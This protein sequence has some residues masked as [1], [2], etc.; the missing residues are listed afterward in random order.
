MKHAS[1]DLLRWVGW[2]LTSL[3]IVADGRLAAGKDEIWRLS[4]SAVLG[5]GEKDGVVI[6]D[7]G[8]VRLARGMSKTSE[9]EAARV[10]DLARLPEGTVVAATGD[11]GRV[12]SRRGDEAWK[13]LAEAG[14]SQALALAAGGDGSLVVGTGPGGWVV[15]VRFEGGEGAEKRER[16]G[17]EVK[18]VWDL[19]YGR[20]GTLYAA[21]GPAGQLW[22]KETGT[23]GKWT[24]VLDS[25]QAHLLSVAVAEDGVVSAGSDGG[26]LIYQVGRGG[27]VE[28][29]LDAPQE[30]IRCLATGPDGALYAGTASGSGASGGRR[31]TARLD[32]GGRIVRRASLRSAQERER[33]DD[34]AG[35]TARLQAGAAGENVVYRIERGGPAR[36]IFRAK[37]LVH[38]LAW[39]G[40]R[41]LVGTG[42]EGTIYEVRG[43]GRETTP[44]AKLDHGQILSLLAEPGGVVW[45]GCGSPGAVVRLEAA[46]RERGSLTSEVFDTKLASRFGS[47]EWRGRERAGTGVA[48]EVRTGGVAEP[49]ATWSAWTAARAPIPQGRFV[50]WRATL[51]SGAGGKASPELESV[52]VAY[53][54]LNLPPEIG[55]ITVPDLTT[56]D[57]AARRTRLELKWEASDPN[58]DELV[59]RLAIRKD[60]W[61]EWLPIGGEAALSEKTFA[62]DTTTVPAGRYTLRV[63]ASDRRSNPAEEA[64]EREKASEPFVVDHEAPEV[65]V[66]VDQ[67]SGSAKVEARDGLTRLVKVEAS[68]DGGDWNACFPVDRIFDSTGE[69]ID[70]PLGELKPGTHVLVVRATDAAGNVGAGDLV[71]RAG[72]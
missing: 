59:Y 54:T 28:V 38:A 1:R 61:P 31:D 39:Q 52:A 72:E 12:Y 63:T 9:L 42:P 14:D 15:P 36:E 45:A 30:E 23:G 25:P 53:R 49:D 35:G 65:K 33:P 62:W 68:I 69:T 71:F 44:L 60:D 8:I 21:T 64:L 2:V 32:A 17:P 6:S 56:G 5:R 3:A 48:L 34:A 66:S 13:V 55:A 22:K 41:L 10:W 70:L 16:P 37:A 67:G 40:E 11:A 20:D 51:S 26:A 50:Q 19:A 47:L 43:L 4:G 46:H 27:K 18:Y 24:L 58:E 29:I 7:A 57:G